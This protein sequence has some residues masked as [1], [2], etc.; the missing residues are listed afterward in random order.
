[1]TNHDITHVLASIGEAKR[2]LDAEP[3]YIHR[4]DELVKHNEE[5]G[6][7]I[8]HRELRIHELKNENSALIQQLRSVEAE[9]DDAGFRHLEEADKVQ[10]LLTLVRQIGG[11]I[12]KCVSAIEG[13]PLVV[14]N[15]HEL[16]NDR[17]ELHNLR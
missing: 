11:D 15:Q 2:A 10:A 16:D 5:L 3:Q 6:R 1:M 12:L 4:I 8:G 13:T 9:R 14:V 7:T 17:T